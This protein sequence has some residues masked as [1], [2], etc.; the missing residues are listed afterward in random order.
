MIIAFALPFI[1]V[2]TENALTLHNIHTAI[3]NANGILS[4]LDALTGVKYS[5]NHVISTLLQIC[6]T[7]AMPTVYLLI[8]N[9]MRKNKQKK[10]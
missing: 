5:Q 2:L 1:I 9:F 10:L 4:Y 8:G 7:A 6:F 3:N